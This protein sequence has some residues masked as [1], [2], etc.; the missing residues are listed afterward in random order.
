MTSTKEWVKGYGRAAAG[1]GIT[2]N[3]YSEDST[4]NLGV[5]PIQRPKKP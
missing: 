3:K 2:K 1:Y 5:I 4:A